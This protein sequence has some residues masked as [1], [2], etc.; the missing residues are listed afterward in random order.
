ML[1]I[2]YVCESSSIKENY[3]FFCSSCS[4]KT[5]YC[6]NCNKVLDIVL[7]SKLFK[8]GNC[9]NL[10]STIK[11]EI[12]YNVF[13]DNSLTLKNDEESY[14]Q[15]IINLMQNKNLFPNSSTQNQVSSFNN[16]MILHTDYSQSSSNFKSKHICN[17]YIKK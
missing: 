9:K 11:K 3:L 13:E 5:S 15:N 1:R 16:P 8:C 7:N 14:R 12:H 10:V 2:C 4:K 6:S 17:F